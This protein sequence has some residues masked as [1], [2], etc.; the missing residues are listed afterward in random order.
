MSTHILTAV[1]SCGQLKG[2]L[3][4]TAQ[5]LAHRASSSGFVRVSYGYLASKTH[6]SIRTMIRHVHRLEDL[7]LLRKQ[8]VWISV[9]RCA[10]NVYELLIRP[11]HRRASVTVA[12]KLPEARREEEKF[13]TIGEEIARLRRGMRLWTLGSLQ[14]QS[15]QEAVQRLEALL[16]P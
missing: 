3:L 14:W 7:G 5:E 9:N 1:R 13:G 6:Q 16:P 15:C 10:V 8:R 12:E 11:L 4:L 2:S